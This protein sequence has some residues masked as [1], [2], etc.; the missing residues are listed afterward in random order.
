MLVF[1]NLANSFQLGTEEQRTVRSNPSSFCG[2][3]TA[4]SF[5]L[6]QLENGPRALVGKEPSC[7]SHNILNHI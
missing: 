3:S 5:L 6:S 1:K 2:C 4:T 7:V